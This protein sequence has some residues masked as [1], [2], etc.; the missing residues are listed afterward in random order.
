MPLIPGDGDKQI[1]EVKISL[2]QS[3]LI[4]KGEKPLH[5]TLEQQMQLNWEGIIENSEVSRIYLTTSPQ[6]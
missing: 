2:G 4:G 3:L 5:F 6:P 1:S